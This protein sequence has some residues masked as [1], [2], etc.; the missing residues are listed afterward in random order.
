MNETEPK[1]SF[2]KD[3][4]FKVGLLAIGLIIAMAI[5]QSVVVVPRDRLVAEELRDDEEARERDLCLAGA[6][7]DF[8]ADWELNSAQVIGQEEGVRSWTNP[9]IKES[10]EESYREA[11]DL[12]FKRYPVD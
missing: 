4:W 11:R 10:V 9:R 12:C 6:R 1:S 2:W 5:Y 7:D 3:N 8:R